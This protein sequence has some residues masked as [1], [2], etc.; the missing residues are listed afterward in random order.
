MARD[1][2]AERGKT[3]L[4][5]TRYDELPFEAGGGDS[6]PGIGLAMLLVR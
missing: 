1:L 4:Y 5:N 6:I 2:G 3:V